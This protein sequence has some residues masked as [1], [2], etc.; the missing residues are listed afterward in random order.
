[1][2]PAREDTLFLDESGTM[3]PGLQV[4]L[5]RVLE[6]RQVM[7]VSGRKMLPVNFR[8]IGATNAD[9]EEQVESGEFHEDLFYRINVIL[10][11][12]PRSGSGARTSRCRPS[13]PCT[14]T[15]TRTG[16]PGS[17]MRRWG[18]F[19]PKMWKGNVRELENVIERALILAEGE[20]ICPDELPPGTSPALN[21][22]APAMSATN[23]AEAPSPRPRRGL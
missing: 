4:K 12:S 18:G 11:I 7:R 10:F 2:E 21:H 8:L 14:S 5:L 22:S 13:A 1:M 23:G 17:Q 9:L 19:R 16:P 20:K 6:E 3:S 15:P